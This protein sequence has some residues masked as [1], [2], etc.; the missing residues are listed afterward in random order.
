MNVRVC[1]TKGFVHELHDVV[2]VKHE[3]GVCLIKHKKGAKVEIAEFP[4]VNIER[5][6]QKDIR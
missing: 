6:D 1:T 2:W 3:N 5:I 4:L